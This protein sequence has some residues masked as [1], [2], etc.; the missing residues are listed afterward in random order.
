MA[1]SK[2][3]KQNIQKY[4]LVKLLKPF[5]TK[6]QGEEIVIPAGSIGDVEKI[7]RNRALV[8]FWEVGY[9]FYVPLTS[10]KRTVR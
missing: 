2:Q 1:R 8:N 7:H 6:F 9:A 5:K 3:K 4:N 10:L